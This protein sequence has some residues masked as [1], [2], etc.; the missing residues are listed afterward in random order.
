VYTHKATREGL[1]VSISIFGEHGE[2]FARRLS[3]NEL[4]DSEMLSAEMTTCDS[5]GFRRFTFSIEQRP[6]PSAKAK[7]TTA[8]SHRRREASALISWFKQRRSPSQAIPLTQPLVDKVVL[9]PA[10]VSFQKPMPQIGL[11]DGKSLA[12]W[13]PTGPESAQT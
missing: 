12:T 9:Y 13:S 11:P 5:D 7:M 4:E 3:E 2:R 6:L 1:K 8:P 10:A